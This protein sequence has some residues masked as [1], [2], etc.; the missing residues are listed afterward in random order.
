MKLRIKNCVYFILLTIIFISCGIVTN[1]YTEGNYVSK[2]SFSLKPSYRDSTESATYISGAIH[3]TNGKTG[4][5]T[6][7]SSTFSLI[8]IHKAITKE[9][10]NFFYRGY[11][12]GGNYKANNQIDL[13]GGDKT[14]V[15]GGVSSEINYNLPSKYID[16][17]VMGAKLSYQYEGGEFATFRENAYMLG[18]IGNERHKLGSFRLNVTSELIFKLQDAD[19]G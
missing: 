11:L 15:G 14:F 12:H 5:N 4:F 10:M 3:G 6:G 1:Q 18:R 19:F 9:H 13:P 8:N 7:E 2:S 17:R 16:W